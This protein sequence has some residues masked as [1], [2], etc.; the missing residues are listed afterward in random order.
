M[1]R[2]L[3]IG[4]RHGRPPA[5]VAIA[6]MLRHPAVTGAIVGARRPSQVNGFTGAAGFRLA[7]EEIA[8]IG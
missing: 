7:A 6:W 8:E 1:K 5:E 4:A 3:A 2:L